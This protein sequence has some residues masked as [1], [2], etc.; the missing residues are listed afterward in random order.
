VLL[1]ERGGR[2]NLPVNLECKHSDV[3][4][5]M[6]IT[7]DVVGLAPEDLVENLVHRGD[8]ERLEFS[9]EPNGL[10]VGGTCFGVV[11]RADRSL[12]A[13]A[14]QAIAMIRT[15]DAKFEAIGEQA[16]GQ[17]KLAL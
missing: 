10:L 14:L 6:V 3:L 2:R 12:S 4:I 13:L 11:H 17:F 15:E 9:D 5:Q 8:V 16:L 7:S 1:A